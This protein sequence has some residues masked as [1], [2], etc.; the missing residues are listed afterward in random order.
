MASDPAVAAVALCVDLVPEL[1]GDDAY[2]AA[3]F[4]AAAATDVPLAVIANLPSAIDREAA[5]RLRAAGVPVLE[6]TRSGLAAL[7]HL[8]AFGRPAAPAVAPP[9]D[10]ARRRRWAGR[11]ADGLGALEGFALLADYGIASPAAR[12]AT[13]RAES[14]AAADDVGYPCVLKSIRRGL[15]HKSDAG[16]VLLDLHSPGE[17]AAAY[18][19]LS[20]RLGPD[21]LVAAMAPAATVELAMGIVR[22]P[23]LGPLVVA[24]AG[25]VLVEQLADRAVGLPPLDAAAATRML[26]R[27]AVRKLLAGGH[28]RPA[29][30]L[31]AVVAALT[32]LSRLAEELGDA[33]EALDVNPVACGPAG[34]VALDVLVLAASGG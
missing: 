29:A 23:Q 27:L 31:D 24:G 17:V 14:V 9:I 33:L 8:L 25:G 34:A 2:P 7:G 10:P 28:G 6:G 20:A 32:A 19:D 11:L 21:V 12:I 4:D 16:G 26:D 3:V 15:D 30:D 5:A 22:D 18:H 13:D 1:D